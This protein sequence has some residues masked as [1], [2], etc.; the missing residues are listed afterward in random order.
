[1]A[2]RTA[3][4]LALSLLLGGVLGVGCGKKGNPQP[5]LAAIPERTTDLSVEQ[6]GTNAMLRF[7]YP[8]R[9]VNG[10]RLTDLA[11]IDVYRVDQ[12][13]AALL[14]EVR[15]RAAASSADHAPLASER[16]R[17]LALRA[18]EQG[19][20]AQAHRIARL[21]SA[22]LAEL[23]RGAEIVY[24]G[25]IGAPGARWPKSIGFAVVSR[26]KRG[27]RSELSNVAV[28]DPL[29]PPGPPELLPLEVSEGQVCVSWRPPAVNL[30]GGAVDVGGYFVYR[31]DLAEPDYGEPLNSAPV[32]VPLYRDTTVVAGAAYVYVVRATVKSHPKIAGAPSEEDGVVYR[33]VYPPPPV[34]RLD[35]LPEARVIHLIWQPVA[36]PDLAGYLIDRSVDGA[37][38]DRLNTRPVEEPFYDDRDVAAGH[39]YRYWVRSV[40]RT[41]NQSAD[42]PVAEAE[43]F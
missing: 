36:A 7:R 26:R 22:R 34:A 20:F 29:V 38:R 15:P 40:D 10:E 42:S 5:P 33:D 17:S 18:H 31:R 1:M 3:E 8:E 21:S 24:S 43:P 28:L 11:Q 35:A 13:P 14:Q 23:S 37:K 27:E 12:P 19:F 39:R 9:L 30:E 16:Q 2:G 6:E 25:S 41:G 4:R 32:E